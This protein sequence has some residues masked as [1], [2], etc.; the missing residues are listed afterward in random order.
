MLL[1]I[2]C[3]V[4]VPTGMQGAAPYAVQR[5][6]VRRLALCWAYAPHHGPVACT[7]RHDEARQ[8]QPSQPA[9]APRAPQQ[10]PPSRQSTPQLQTQ[11]HATQQ[12][13]E[14]KPRP[15]EAEAR[16]AEVGKSSD[17][18]SQDVHHPAAPGSTAPAQHE[19]GSTPHGRP[20]APTPLPAHAPAGSRAA[21]PARAGRPPQPG[22]STAGAAK[23]GAWSLPQCMVLRQPVAGAAHD[24]CRSCSRAVEAGRTAGHGDA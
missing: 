20:H 7:C 24:A 13:P 14:A 17:D 2:D 5:P 21:K 15:A 12:R 6:A 11:P 19:R 1:T 22:G 10:G 4:H 23:A 8:P 9:D 18:S 3:A 16:P